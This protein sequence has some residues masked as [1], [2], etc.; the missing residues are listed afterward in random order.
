MVIAFDTK[1]VYCNKANSAINVIASKA[2]SH[3][4]ES[5]SF[6]YLNKRPCFC[7]VRHLTKAKM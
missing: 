6:A 7:I 3:L 2:E 4:S 1:D 5:P